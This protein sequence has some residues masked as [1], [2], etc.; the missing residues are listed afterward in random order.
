MKKLILVLIIGLLLSACS[1]VSRNVVL[2][3]PASNPIPLAGVSQPVGRMWASMLFR[4][5][6]EQVILFGGGRLN[7]MWFWSTGAKDWEAVDQ[8]IP[9]NLTRVGGAIAA[10]D[11]RAD[12][13]IIYFYKG[14]GVPGETW[15]YDF[16]TSAWRNLKA[17]NTPIGRRFTTLVYDS[18]SDRIIL[19]GGVLS[20]DSSAPTDETWAFDYAANRW[21]QMNPAA[22]PPAVYYLQAVYESKSDRVIVWG[23]RPAASENAVWSYDYNRDTWTKVVYQDGPRQDGDGALVYAADLNRVFLYINSQFWSY[24]PVSNHWENLSNPN[25]PGERYGASMVYDEKDHRLLLFGGT[26][27]ETDTWLYDPANQ[28]WSVIKSNKAT[29]PKRQE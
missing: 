14:I 6:S 18:E 16:Q 15:A 20:D 2:K 28:V 3:Q 25:G 1:P 21:T 24:D 11:S 26:G 7:D 4:S 27:G 23:G 5:K 12:Q 29:V 9:P 13:M 8:G 22:H 10:Y 19:F 17:A